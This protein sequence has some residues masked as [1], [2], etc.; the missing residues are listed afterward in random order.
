MESKQDPYRRERFKNGAEALRW[1]QSRGQI[2]RSKFYEDCNSGHVTIYPDKT[3]SK[4]NVAMYA[5]KHF[6][7]FVRTAPAQSSVVAQ[8]EGMQVSFEHVDP[9][10]NQAEGR[11]MVSRNMLKA[12][13]LKGSAQTINNLILALERQHENMQQQLDEMFE[14]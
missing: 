9:P 5:E 12:A 8:V 10:E 3:V 11:G 13:A 1:L 6:S 14:G 4:F 7:K 2:S